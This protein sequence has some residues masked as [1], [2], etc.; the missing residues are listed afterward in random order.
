LFGPKKKVW[1]EIRTATAASSEI[2]AEDEVTAELG[3][4]G[5]DDE[6]EEI[7]AVEDAPEPQ[8]NLGIQGFQLD[9]ELSENK[10]FVVMLRCSTAYH[11]THRGSTYRQLEM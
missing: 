3:D 8:G 1:S 10:P 9:L 6:G 2:A 7:M 11:L 5:V 4:L